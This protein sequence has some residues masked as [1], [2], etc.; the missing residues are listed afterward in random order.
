MLDP[1]LNVESSIIANVRFVQPGTNLSGL[2]VSKIQAQRTKGEY[3][4]AS[5]VHKELQSGNY[6]VQL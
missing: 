5:S 4:L 3:T 1:R 2:N 6:D